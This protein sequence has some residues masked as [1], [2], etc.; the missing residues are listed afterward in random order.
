MLY[1]MPFWPLLEVFVCIGRLVCTSHAGELCSCSPSRHC[2][3]YRHTLNELLSLLSQLKDN[4][5][6]FTGWSA[7]VKAAC[8]IPDTGQKAGTL[9]LLIKILSSCGPKKIQ[10]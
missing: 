2:L 6:A 4:I 1:Q 5:M 9:E 10:R 3:R 8:V 7:R